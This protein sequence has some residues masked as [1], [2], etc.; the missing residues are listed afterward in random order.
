MKIRL[1]QLRRIIREVVEE[2]S[3]DEDLNDDGKNDFTDVMIARHKASGMSHDKAV[4]KGEKAAD[5]AS[6]A[7]KK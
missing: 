2:A 6:A 1:S 4:E 7:K 3:K 5:K